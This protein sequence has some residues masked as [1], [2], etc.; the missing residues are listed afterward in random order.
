MYVTRNMVS[1]HQNQSLSLLIQNGLSLMT[2]TQRKTLKCNKRSNRFNILGKIRSM[3]S[4][5]WWSH[6]T[7][8][9][10]LWGELRRLKWLLN[11][12]LLILLPQRMIRR[13][14]IWSLSTSRWCSWCTLRWPNLLSRTSNSKSHSN[15]CSRPW[16]R[17][18]ISSQYSFNSNYK[19]CCGKEKTWWR[20]LMSETRRSIN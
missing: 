10:L 11:R 8:P 7:I 12:A 16:N 15:R 17:K 20:A 14:K 4:F 3:L 18:M 1:S 9:S 13:S 19:R 5:Q 6:Q 2:T